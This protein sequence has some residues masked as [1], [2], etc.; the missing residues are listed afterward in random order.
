M[1]LDVSGNLIAR[2]EADTFVDSVKLNN[3]TLHDNY[4][5]YVDGKAFKKLDRLEVL[6]LSRNYMVTL[7]KDTF[8]DLINLKTVLL[9][10][11]KI[12]E[13][14]EGLFRNNLKIEDIFFDNNIIKVIPA[15]LFQNLNHLV[16]VNF[17]ENLCFSKTFS[18]NFSPLST[19]NNEIKT[20]TKKNTSESIIE[21]LKNELKISEQNEA[22]LINNN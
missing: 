13:L 8:S 22:N 5:D 20:C 2:L 3:I 18:I 15:N 4:I 9:Y 21:R 6:D 12:E 17:A 16:V 14:P 11:N 10:Q 1:E 19:L 7:H